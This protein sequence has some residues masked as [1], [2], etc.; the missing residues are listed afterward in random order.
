MPPKLKV[1]LYMLKISS[2][3]PHCLNFLH[4][5]LQG[6]F[7]FFVHILKQTFNIAFK[8][9]EAVFPQTAVSRSHLVK[10]LTY[11]D[12][13]LHFKWPTTTNTLSQTLYGQTLYRG[14]LATFQ[15]IPQCKRCTIIILSSFHR[16]EIIMGRP[17]IHLE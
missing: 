14:Q 6:Y 15:S 11:T 13:Q 1:L 8:L 9:P 4:P 5:R 3:P 17:I 2:L 12:M 10:N 16:T 7:L